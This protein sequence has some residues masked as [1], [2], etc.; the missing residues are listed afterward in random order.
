MHIIELIGNMVDAGKDERLARLRSHIAR[1]E[2]GDAGRRIS[3]GPCPAAGGGGDDRAAGA[4]SLESGPA[5]GASDTGASG[6]GR[7]ALPFGIAEIDRRLPGHGLQLGRLHEIVGAIEGAGTGFAVHLLRRLMAQE[8]RQVWG[9]GGGP[10]FWCAPQASLYAPGL[11]CRGLAVDRLIMVTAPRREDRLWAMEECL[12]CSGVLAVVGELQARERIDLTAS[13][14][15]QLA[16]GQGGAMAL[17]LRPPVWRPHEWRQDEAPDGG[18]SEDEGA[19]GASAAVT[20]WHVR[21]LPAARAGAEAGSSPDNDDMG[22]HSC[23]RLVLSRSRGG[24]RHGWMV[25]VDHA[26]GDFALASPLRDR[27]GA[28]A[29]KQAVA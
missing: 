14:R 19:L 27:S 24:A 2:G 13:R 23:W 28:T 4:A 18:G 22:R 6:A 8:S 3:I 11:A 20:R 10:V 16:A 26:T 1:I 7:P 5:P 17:L 15:L 12:R 25:E 9:T 29:D 21:S